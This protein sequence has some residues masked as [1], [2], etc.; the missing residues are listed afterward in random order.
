MLDLS[1]AHPHLYLLFETNSL[2]IF[3]ES[4]RI[5]SPMT[6]QLISLEAA[7]EENYF[8]TYLSCTDTIDNLKRNIRRN[9]CF[10]LSR[11]LLSPTSK[12]DD[13]AFSEA[14]A[15][16]WC[17]TILF[18]S[19][20]D[21]LEPQLSWLRKHRFGKQALRRLQEVFNCLYVLLRPLTAS[22][23]MATEVGIVRDRD[24]DHKWVA[25]EE[26]E[27]WGWWVLSRG[28]DVVEK[29]VEIEDDEEERWDI[30]VEQGLD[31]W[32]SADGG[33][34]AAFL[35]E[36]VGK[37]YRERCEEEGF[38]GLFGM[39]GPWGPTSERV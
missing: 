1:F 13:E 38:V 30:V 33:R 10:F 31:E 39:T 15:A 32:D 28:L 9:C 25:V 36:A 20:P 22:T 37:M 34:E 8:A 23:Q 35:R 11:E 14:L 21:E 7:D 2:A 12:E 16:I 3:Q 17:F 26:C 18:S 6:H 4:L 29:V 5:Y 27:R 19:T 24:I